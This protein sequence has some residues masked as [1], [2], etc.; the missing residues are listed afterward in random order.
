M[1]FCPKPVINFES[2]L[3]KVKSNKRLYLKRYQSDNHTDNQKSV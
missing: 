2:N 3:E 1:K